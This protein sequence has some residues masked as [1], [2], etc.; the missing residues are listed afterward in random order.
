M[1]NNQIHLFVCLFVLNF[2][3]YYIGPSNLKSI[4]FLI[5]QRFLMD[6]PYY[7]ILNAIKKMETRWFLLPKQ[8]PCCLL[9]TIFFSFF[10]NGF[11][12]GQ[13]ELYKDGVLM[14]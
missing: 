5:F 13:R 12:Y 6:F 2:E 11:V 10:R 8:N 9:E 1:E 7:F 14:I 4:R 3:I